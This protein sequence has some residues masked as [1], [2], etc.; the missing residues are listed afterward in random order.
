MHHSGEEWKRFGPQVGRFFLISYDVNIDLTD[1][2]NRYEQADDRNGR[3]CQVVLGHRLNNSEN[4]IRQILGFR[5]ERNQLY[6]VVDV[7]D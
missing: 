7:D 4:F 6:F 1:Y 2:I 5:D 3:H